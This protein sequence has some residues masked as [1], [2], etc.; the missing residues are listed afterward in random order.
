MA[1][2]AS[3]QATGAATAYTM[4]LESWAGASA[5]VQV[6]GAAYQDLAGNTGRQDKQ[7]AVSVH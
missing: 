4:W 3:G 6:M 2:T 1:F 5:V 7:L